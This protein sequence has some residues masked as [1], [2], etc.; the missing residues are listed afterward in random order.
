MEQKVLVINSGSS[1]IKYKLLAMNSRETL[2]EGKIEAKGD[3]DDALRHLG[4]QLQAVAPLAD[5]IIAVGHRVFT[6]V[7]NSRAR[8]TSTMARYNRWCRLSATLHC[9]PDRLSPESAWLKGSSPISPRW[10]SSTRHFT[11]RYQSM[12]ARTLCRGRLP[13]H[14]ALGAQG[15]TASRLNTP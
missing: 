11:R 3:F 6:G 2:L 13:R 8:P 5:G 1:S 9:T 10:Q 14:M 7:V 4:H 15:F 12:R